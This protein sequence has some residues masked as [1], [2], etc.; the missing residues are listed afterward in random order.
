MSNI[1]RLLAEPAVQQADIIFA[2][3]GG[4][5]IDTAKT[6]ADLAHKEAFSFP[7][8]CSNCSAATAIAVVYH[9]NGS[10]S[11][12]HYPACPTHIF[13]NPQIVAEAPAEYFW[14]GIGDA[15]S[16]QCEVEYASSGK[17]LSHTAQLGV[18]LAKACTEP[19]ITYGP[20]GLED[21]RNNVE[22]PAV[23][24]IALDIII[25]T[26]YVSNLTNQPTFY[27]NSSIAHAF[28]NASTSI[29]RPGTYLHGQVVSFGVLVLHAFTGNEAELDRI[30]R[31]NCSIGLPVTLE[32]IGLTEQDLP[33]IA[34]AATQTNEWKNLPYPTSVDQFVEAIRKADAYGRMILG[35]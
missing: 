13:I 23:E 12:Y 14:A 26:G 29:A 9:D 18:A 10:F 8:I 7:T 27:Y 6:T 34:Q 31:F 24:E 17:E 25:S 30:A 16:K 4:K 22:S 35:K 32:E 5:A 11:H 15:L 28:Y 3:G 20:Q 2:V 1:N 33:E 19:L 21:V